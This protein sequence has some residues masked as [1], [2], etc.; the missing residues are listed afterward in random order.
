MSRRVH[1]CALAASMSMIALAGLTGCGQ[2]NSVAADRA[3]GG[4][5]LTILAASSLIDAFGELGKTFEEQNEGVTVKQSFESSSTLLTQIQQGA[6]AEVFASAA[7]EEM[8]TAVKDGLV[9]GKPEVFVKNR[10][11]IM[12]PKDNPAG[13]REFRDVAKPDIKLVLAQKDVPAAD[14]ALEILDK[15]NAEYGAGFEKDVLSNVVS[16]EP[17]VRA[18][19]NRVVVGDADATFGYASDY[20]PDIRG[21]VKVVPIPPDLNIIA[22]YPIAALDGAKSPELAKKWVELV[23]SKEGQRVLEKWNFESAA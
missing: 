5:T 17:D 14:Y 16:R 21:R 23:T 8:K 3:N 7:K 11:I 19:V 20:T 6:P 4:E 12:V 13:I 2:D 15:A 9:A 18:S 10:E 22:T 1:L